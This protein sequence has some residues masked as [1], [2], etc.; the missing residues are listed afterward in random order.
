M[1]KQD[2][3]E[4]R[5]GW[6]L[7]LSS[8]IGIA[9]GLSGIAFYTFGAFIVPLSE[10]FDW[11]RGKVSI[12]A[13]F[14]IVGTAI[15]APVV[16]T[17]I[18]R[19]GART[20]GLASMLLLALG[21]CLLTQLGGNLWQFYAA[22]LCIALIGGG[23]TPVVWTRAIN[24]SFDRRRGLA[25]GLALAGSGVT[26]IF[27]PALV[28]VLIQEYGWRAGYMGIGGFILLFAAPIVFALFREP[29]GREASMNV[30]N[31]SDEA[32]Q[33]T[34]KTLPE[35]LRAPAFWLIAGGF[36]LV[37]AV[38]AG[39]LINI[40]PM[41]IDKGLAASE[42]AEIAGYLGL[43]VVL[44]RVGVGHVIDRVPAHQVARCMLLLTAL[45]CWLLSIEGQPIWVLVLGVVGLGLAAAA[46]VDLVAFLTSRHLGMKCYGKIY[47][48][49]T[50]SFYL[51]AALGPIAVGLAY[52]HFANY[53]FVLYV[54]SALLICGSFIVGALGEPPDSCNEQH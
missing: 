19:Y 32:Q 43:A 1:S 33:L 39:L 6:K 13:S 41:L 24:L 36:F 27:G 34:G 7:L 51:G 23:T 38:V 52:D 10:A 44:G 31:D 29:A 3:N 11:S 20:V 12:A 54:A 53:Q 5:R 8:S 22:W 15:T 42:A 26:G 30:A 37:S 35:A 16:G 2:T 48:L 18:D 28:T 47:G 49:Q 21:Y 50:S 46:E 17:I 40:V 14:L 4:M 9:A 25:L 45:G